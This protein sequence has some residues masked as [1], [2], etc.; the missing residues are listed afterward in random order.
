MKIYLP[1]W[2]LSQLVTELSKEATEQSVSSQHKGSMSCLN[3]PLSSFPRFCTWA[4]SGGRG[5]PFILYKAHHNNSV[6]WR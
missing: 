1:Q 5:T 2:K 3:L 6:N 4:G